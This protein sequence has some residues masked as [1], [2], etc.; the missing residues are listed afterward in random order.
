MDRPEAL[1]WGYRSF[2]AFLVTLTIALLTL[3]ASIAL[4]APAANPAWAIFRT[5]RNEALATLTSIQT[6]LDSEEKRIS[7]RN[8]LAKTDSARSPKPRDQFRASLYWDGA[9]I[10][11]Y[12][13]TF[14]A[15]RKLMSNLYS[16]LSWKFTVNWSAW[17]GGNELF[18][19]WFTE[20]REH[21]PASLDDWLKT[22]SRACGRLWIWSGRWLFPPLVAAA[23][24]ADLV[25]DGM[26][27]NAI[28]SDT[29][30]ISAQFANILWCASCL[31]FTMLLI[32]I[33]WIA[34]GVAFALYRE[35]WILQYFYFVRTPVI[36]ALLLYGLGA[37]GILGPATVRAA[38]E[39]DSPWMFFVLTLEAFIAAAVCALCGALI[40]DEASARFKTG[41]EASGSE[42]FAWARW[43]WVDP[44]G[45]MLGLPFF[46]VALP[47]IIALVMQRSERVSIPEVLLALAAAAA[48]AWGLL[49]L[50][51]VLCRPNRPAYWFLLAP[52]PCVLVAGWGAFGNWTYA[53]VMAVVILLVLIGL[54]L[55]PES[56]EDFWIA[57]FTIGVWCLFMI[58]ASVETNY[59]AATWPVVIVLGS[60]SLIAIAYRYW[61][62]LGSVLL[63][64]SGGAIVVWIARTESRVVV[65]L[66]LV[67]IV[68]LLFGV[69]RTLGELVTLLARLAGP[70]F[71]V[72][73]ATL[74]PCIESSR[75][76]STGKVVSGHA[77]MLGLNLVVFTVYIVCG[78]I[79]YPNA[80]RSALLPASHTLVFVQLWIMLFVLGFSLLTFFLD[81]YR[82][83]AIL[84]AA[85]YLSFAY[86][87]FGVDHRFPVWERP[88][89][90]GRSTVAGAARSRLHKMSEKN[91]NGNVTVL[92]LSGGGITAAGWTTKVL[93]ELDREFD[94]FS[95]SVHFVSSVSGGSVGGM[96]FL[97]SFLPEG[98]IKRTGDER[99]PAFAFATESSLEAT[100]WG[101]VYPDS[102]RPFIL[103][104][105]N[106]LSRSS[107]MERI[108]QAYLTQMRD[109]LSLA[110]VRTSEAPRDRFSD[111]ERRA[112]DGSLP[113]VAFNCTIIE[114]GRHLAISSVRFPARIGDAV[115]IIHGRT[116]HDDYGDV[117]IDKVTAARLSATFPYVSPVASPV[118]KANEPP[119]EELYYW[120]PP[121]HFADGGYFDNHGHI[122]AFEWVQAVLADT[123]LANEI[124]GNVVVIQINA[125]PPGLTESVEKTSKR[126]GSWFPMI[127]G[128]AEGLYKV[129]TA[130]QAARGEMEFGALVEAHDGKVRH[131]SIEPP[132]GLR[133]GS[134]LSWRL[135]EKNKVD[136]EAA[137]IE[138]KTTD[139]YKRI[140]SLYTR[141]AAG[142]RT[143]SQQPKRDRQ[144]V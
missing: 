85:I 20:Q 24:I 1:K 5:P 63:C 27:F 132:L 92:C 87:T 11:C 86:Y 140:E 108:W 42:E 13:L 97:E 50:I 45:A 78:F 32:G 23:V 17:K 35:S 84:L 61:K 3:H 72:K 88:D 71:Y 6:T 81:R 142:S 80:D 28:A 53:S 73:S 15:T 110:S 49:K 138:F 7:E 62:M 137:W 39:I 70:G 109:R 19:Q 117:D 91:T 134:V 52:I 106:T 16:N 139:E 4:P 75:D 40:W 46:V 65:S 8:A 122:A 93:T 55:L 26:L 14:V 64:V 114:T 18:R 107:A 9:L 69:R 41:I 126:S 12:L 43:L 22:V 59:A 135:S 34:F 60:A 104:I 127:G 48:V 101:L 121:K 2:V 36:G 83:P 21:K 102:L 56:I 30:E 111:W 37:V 105:P 96:Y 123:N 128:P 76:E 98:E 119:Y 51:D 54:E 141:R 66:G 44:R 77:R 33:V 82:V 89:I 115:S 68:V 129:R 144:R 131:H 120:T 95:A 57:L 29:G 10:V 116:L 124:K 94:D 118:F 79:F 130:T 103:A 125:F 100:A 74:P 112:A 99:Q 58:G 38:L 25:E 67:L 47:L 133:G 136:L 31:K 113:A 143:T 90:P